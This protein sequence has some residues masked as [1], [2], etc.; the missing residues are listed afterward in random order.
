VLTQTL[1]ALQSLLLALVAFRAEPGTLAVVE[2]AVLSMVQGMFR[3]SP[4]LV[5][6]LAG[7]LIVFIVFVAWST[8]TVERREYVLEQ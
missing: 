8:W 2:V 6:S 4:S 1:S 5:G 7:L 3:E